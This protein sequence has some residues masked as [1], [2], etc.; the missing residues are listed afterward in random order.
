MDLYIEL[1]TMKQSLVTRK[2]RKVRKLKRL[3]PQI[4]IRIFY[5]KDYH[6][7]MAK[8]GLLEDQPE[9]SIPTRDVE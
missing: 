4:N 1:T 6:R 5:Q 9:I 2:N 3:Y 7:L 8:Y